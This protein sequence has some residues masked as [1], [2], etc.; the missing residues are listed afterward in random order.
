MIDLVMID[1]D[2]VYDW[3]EEEDG[4]IGPYHIL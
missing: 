3:E 1:I 2:W 4:E